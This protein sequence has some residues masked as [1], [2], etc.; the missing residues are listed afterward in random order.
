LSVLF[1]SHSSQD[2]DAAIKVRDW[3]KHNGWTEVYLDLDPLRGNAPGQRW[4]ENLKQVVERCSGML[5]LM[6]PNWAESRWCQA[7]FL[8]AKLMGKKI[9]PLFVAPTPLDEVPVELKATF[10]IAD[11]SLAEKEAEGLERLAIGLKR[12]GLDPNSFEWPPPG[13]SHRPI[14]RGLQSLDEQ[15]AAIF[16]GRDALITKGLDALRRMREGASE[17]MLVI[18]GAS[19]AGKSSFLKAGLIARLK[20]D[21]QNFLVLPIV[22]P[23]RAALTG[24]RGLA[25][26]LSYDPARLNTAEDF[27][28]ALATLR[29]PVIEQMKQLAQSAGDSYATRPPTVVIAVDQAEELFGAENVEAAQVLRLLASAVGVDANTIIVAT[30]RSD[31]FEKLQGESRLADVSRLPFDLPQISH[32]LFKEVIE[33]PARLSSPPLTIEPALTDTLLN[34]LAADDALPLLAFTLEKLSLL[35]R[36]GGVLT[37]AK[38]VEELGGLHGAITGAVEAAFVAAQRDPALPQERVEIERLARAAF[39]PALV[40]LDD[41]HAEPRRRVERLDALPEATLPLVRHLI[42]QRLLVI[43]RSRIGGIETNTVEVAHE[44]ILRQWRTLRAWIA[45]ERDALR[46][47]DGVRTAAAEWHIHQD[48]ENPEQSKSWLTHQGGRLEEAEALIT[49]PGFANALDPDELEYLSACRASENAERLREKGGIARTRRLQRSIGVLIAIAAVVVIVGAAGIVVLLAGTAART[50][51]TLASLA[52]KEAETGNYDA[53]A[54][55]ALAGLAG[56]DWPVLGFRGDEAKAELV[57]SANASR[58]LAVLRGHDHGVF[59][60]A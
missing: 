14:Y 21:R 11:I 58:A 12:A 5:V 1:I 25:F 29:A 9:F 57:G 43:D 17:R 38:Y 51:V 49:R 8:A 13:D 47:L 18:L 59:S 45:E 20:R 22:R 33:G 19:G 44:A 7:E 6:S 31:A 60:A 53:A 15:D 26:S 37:L 34:D 24:A 56:A 3:L 23:G 41:A 52:G 40:Q 32:G 48:K 2:N 54:R 16:F 46:A 42:D 35:H 55:Y 10:Q 4:E 27:V 39:V 28:E 36:G 50:S 30:I